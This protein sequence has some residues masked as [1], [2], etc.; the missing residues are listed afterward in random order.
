M[1][2][3][4]A[5][6]M[7]GVTE[8]KEKRSLFELGNAGL[9]HGGLH[10]DIG[11]GYSGL[12]LDSGLLSDAHLSHVAPVT[13]LA[14]FAPV[15]HAAEHTHTHS[16]EKVAVPY[17]VERTVVKHI[18]VPQ[19]NFIQFWIQFTKHIDTVMWTAWGFRKMN[20]NWSFIITWC[21]TS[22]RWTKQ[23]N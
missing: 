23:A 15:V 14:S 1:F 7:A 13:S 17:P 10:T 2:A 8:T 6:S 22:N 11:H 18:P 4:V 21:E 9:V 20:L 5:T 12:S 16:I 3:L 19:V